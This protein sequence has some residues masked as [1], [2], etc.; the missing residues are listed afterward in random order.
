MM[1]SMNISEVMKYLPH[2]YP[3]L[4]ID[5]VI[6]CDSG[7][8]ISAI[9]NVTI[10]EHFFAGH[11]PQAPVMPGVLIL[12]AMA[13]ASGLLVLSDEDMKPKK[14]SLFLFVGIEKARFKKPVEPGDQLRIDSTLIRHRRSYGVF[15]AQA[16]VEDQLVASAE[17]MCM[18]KEL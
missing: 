1:K 8:K 17:L 18:F 9:K 12:E 16:F 10:N 13:Q 11:F 7:I 15:D 2:R 5:R 6:R 14:D 3:F 4:L